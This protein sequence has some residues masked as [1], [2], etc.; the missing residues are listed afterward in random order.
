MRFPIDTR[1]LRLVVAG[2]PEP[3]GGG[4]IHHA[5][6]AQSR[7]EDAGRPWRV[8]LRALGDGSG[9]I[10]R[11][12]VASHPRLEPGAEVTVEGMSALTWKGGS[13][14]GMSLRAYAITTARGPA[15]PQGT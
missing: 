1:S 12:T 9:Q 5:R 8:P 4:N 6:D 14:R 15:A 2:V 11:V 10:V 3:V 13:R 7:N